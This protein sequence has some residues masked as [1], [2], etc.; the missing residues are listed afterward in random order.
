MNWIVS[1]LFF[2]DEVSTAHIITEIALKKIDNE[3]LSVICGPSGYEKTYNSQIKELDS[4]IKVYRVRLPKL[5]KNKLFHRFI[6]QLILTIKMG[7]MILIKVKK[8]NKVLITTNPSFLLIVIYFLKKIIEFKLEILVHDVFPDNLLP[9]GLLKKNTLKYEFL[10][11]IYNLSYQCA[12]RI[13]VLGEDMRRLM[14]E[15]ISPNYI[16]IDIVPNWAEDNIRPL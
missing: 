3:Q 2:P 4:R 8:G 16:K 15:K 7:W 12:D 13:I 11:K 1:E 10:N 5:D 6:M 14:L 9:I